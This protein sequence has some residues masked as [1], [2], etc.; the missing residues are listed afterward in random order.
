MPGKGASFSEPTREMSE[1]RMILSKPLNAPPFH[2]VHGLCPILPPEV[3]GSAS[4]RGV[5]EACT[6]AFNT[7]CID[8]SSHTEPH[9]DIAELTLKPAA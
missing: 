9:K 2:I 4:F 1:I 3:N 6:N 8:C 7:Q 5:R